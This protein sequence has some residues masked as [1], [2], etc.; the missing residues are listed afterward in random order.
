MQK[1][2]QK[3]ITTQ[4]LRELFNFHIVSVEGRETSSHPGSQTCFVALFLC[5]YVGKSTII[6]GNPPYIVTNPPFLLKK[7]VVG[8]WRVS[9]RGSAFHS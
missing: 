9:W 4:E 7:G 3:I 2:R 8:A 5:F 1:I 6:V